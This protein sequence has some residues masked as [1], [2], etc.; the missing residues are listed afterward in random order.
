LKPALV[1][2]HG[3][4]LNRGMWAPIAADLGRDFQVVTPDLPGHGARAGE[5]FRLDTAVAMVW[6]VAQSLAPAPIVLCGDSL[7]GYV[8]L[9]SAASLGDQLKGAVLGGCTA[10]F[11]GPA[12]LMYKVQIALTKLLPP[13]KLKAQLEARLRK[14][15]EA[16]PAIIAGGI[17]PGP[18]SDAVDELRK[19]NF[20][21]V[22]A[23]ITVP[24]LLI[25]GSRDWAHVLGERGAL[26]ANPRAMLRRLPGVGHG[27]S[28]SRPAEFAAIVREFV[29]LRIGD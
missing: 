26:A 20:R 24:L 5:P 1:L 12:V 6:E 21:G 14:E 9:A 27:V 7:G 17:S 11:Q 28:L 13:A 23:S 3:A 10:N 22:L 2:V 16:G 15:Y 4:V 19:V 29:S 25:N 8:S 18:Y